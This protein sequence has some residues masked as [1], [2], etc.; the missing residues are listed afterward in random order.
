M[1][2]LSFI[3]MFE[4]HSFAQPEALGKSKNMTCKID[5]ISGNYGHNVPSLSHTILKKK[6]NP[7]NFEKVESF[8]AK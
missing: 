3:N 6:R 2:I 8:V 1:M 7:I 4:G 5:I